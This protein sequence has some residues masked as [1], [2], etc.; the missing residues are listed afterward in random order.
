MRFTVEEI[1]AATGGTRSGD[2]QQVDGVTIDSRAVQGGEL[3]V[4]VVAARD[5]HEFIADALAAGAAAYLTARDPVDGTAVRVAETGAAL[6]DIGRRARGRMD[7]T[8]IGI[9]GSVGKTTVKDLTAAALRSQARTAASERSF[10]NELGVPLTLANAPDDVQAVVVEIGA[11][12][13]G[14]IARLCDV[15]RPHVG[16]VTAVALA[17]TEFF[18][19]LDDVARAKGELVEALPGDG[20]AVLNADDDRVAAMAGR[21]A[22][23]VLTFGAAPGADVRASGVELSEDLRPRFRLRSPWGDADVELAV[24]GAHQVGNAL[25]AAGA[26]LATGAPLEAV[27]AGLA[28]GTASPSRMSLTVAPSGA[29]ILDDSYNANPT[30]VAAALRALAALPARRRTAVLGLMAELG[31]T[32]EDEHRAIAAMATELEVRVIAFVTPAYGVVPVDDV[33]GAV[34]ALGP[35]GPDDAV[36]VKGSRV[37]GL[38]RLAQ[39]LTTNSRQ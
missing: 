35:L 29:R 4:P 23:R 39:R 31:P 9:T 18:G 28:R 21:T 1:A 6:L 15:A 22:A 14:H 38:E 12:G 5:G 2:A 20:T 10:N 25:A 27:A 11:R 30:S 37:A 26:A 7:A 13:Q 3:F 17:H 34:G 16:V 33:D 32:S 8:V 24:H 36:L 19:S